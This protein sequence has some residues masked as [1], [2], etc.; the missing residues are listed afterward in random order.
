[1]PIALI[2]RWKLKN[3]CPDLLKQCLTT[4]AQ[5]VLADEADT[6]AYSVHLTAAPPLDANRDPLN[7]QPGAFPLAE[8]TE[9]TFFEIYRDA[10]A[11]AD[12]VNGPCFT[13]FR[14]KYIDYFLEDSHNPGWPQT[15]TTFLDCESSFFRKDAGTESV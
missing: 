10:Q 3:G 4:L 7:P 5:T 14:T 13:A 12:H 9:V 6:L 15:I 8:Q 1:M 2:S 11:F